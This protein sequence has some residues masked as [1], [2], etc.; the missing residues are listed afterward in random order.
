VAVVRT[1][2]RTLAMGPV[3]AVLAVLAA[4]GAPAQGASG[5]LTKAPD[6]RK[7]ELTFREEFDAFKPWRGTSGVWRT[8][9]GDGKVT[10]VGARTLQANKELQLYVDADM[11]DA[12]GK[13]GLDP[14]AAKDGV[15]TITAD[16]APET[17]K[18]RLGGYGYTSGLITTQPSFRQTYGYFE[19]RAALPRGK[20]LWPAFWLLPAD[21]SW[22][23]EIDVMESIGDPTKVYVTAH[24]KAGK[25]EGIEVKVPDA[26]FHTYAVAWDAKQLV[27]YLDG[28]ESGRQ[29]T[30]PDMHK[31][32][33]L[34]ANLAMGGDWAGA[35]DAS[36]V[37]PARYAIDYI[38]AYR[39]AP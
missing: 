9:F 32:M 2:M 39:F 23:P 25:A 34:L 18:P 6:G 20:G 14:F 16:R 29:P 38:R 11:A 1:V 8:T 7:L 31:P 22:P 12:G 21:L 4:C 37:F 30:P 15:L 26:G 27:W 35:P 28:V 33:Y 36:T 17:L 10:G 3:L 5:P 19:M 24:S 13:V